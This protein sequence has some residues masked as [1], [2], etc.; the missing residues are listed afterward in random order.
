MKKCHF[1][2]L[3]IVSLYIAACT[4]NKETWLSFYNK[5]ST[6][7]GFKDRKGEVKIAPKLAPYIVAGKFDGI[8][9]VID[10]SKPDRSSY[11]LTKTGRIVG[12]DSLYFFDNTPDCECE[13]FIRFKDH[14]SLKMGMFNSNGDAAIPATYNYLAPVRNGLV[15]A[16]AGAKRIQPA[17]VSDEHFN[18]W[19]GGSEVLIDINNKVLIRDFRTTTISTFIL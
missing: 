14:K 4:Q 18:P 6:L 12:R 8:I 19:Q 13:G 3:F 5:D 16:L 15:M 17:D 1:T 11:Y 7:V 10:F 2:L 9:A